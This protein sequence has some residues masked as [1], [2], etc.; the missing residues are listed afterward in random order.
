MVAAKVL[1]SEPWPSMQTPDS[2]QNYFE[3]FGFSPGFEIDASRLHAEQQRLQSVYHPDRYVGA[4]DR[5]KRES[6][7]LAAW[8]NQ[9]Y[10]TLRDPVKRSRYLLEINGAELVDE[11]TTTADTVFLMEQIELREA[12][13]ACRKSS[14]GLNCCAEIESQ[15][16]QRASELAAEFVGFF[17]QGDLDSAQHSSRKMQFI[18][19][20]QDQLAELQ[21]E[22]EDI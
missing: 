11:S 5:E 4:S 18:Q 16:V 1:P 8:I 22:L 20:I 6:V 14:N 17:E 12:L 10:E 3:L 9:A 13:D 21:F 7:Q 15:L 2:T 19:R